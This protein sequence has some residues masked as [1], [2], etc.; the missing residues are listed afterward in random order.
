MKAWQHHINCEKLKTSYGDVFRLLGITDSK[1]LKYSN[2]IRE[3]FTKKEELEFTSYVAY[4][5]FDI[6]FILSFIK[7]SEENKE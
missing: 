2:K 7:Q 1:I 5:S 3:G 4:H 6:R